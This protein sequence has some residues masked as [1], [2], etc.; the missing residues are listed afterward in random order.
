MWRESCCFPSSLL[1][2]GFSELRVAGASADYIPGA[3]TAPGSNVGSG[4]GAAPRQ[5]GQRAVGPECER[6]Y[7]VQPPT[8]RGGGP[9][10]P[11]LTRSQYLLSWLV[12]PDLFHILRPHL[13]ALI[14]CLVRPGLAQRFPGRRAVYW[15]VLR[16]HGSAWGWCLNHRF[17]QELQASSKGKLQE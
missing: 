10:P 12:T 15:L 3:L 17:S 5:A 1:L 14:L 8:S 9:K 6:M 16:S 4:A 11:R 7:R 13:H 2:S